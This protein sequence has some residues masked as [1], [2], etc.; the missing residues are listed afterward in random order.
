MIVMM[1]NCVLKH[2][3]SQITEIVLAKYVVGTL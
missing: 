2:C 1:N 3:P